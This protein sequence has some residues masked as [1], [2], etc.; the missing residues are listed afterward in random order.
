MSTIEF[1]PAELAYIARQDR[2]RFLFKRGQDLTDADAA[3]LARNLTL[4]P[5]RR[6]ELVAHAAELAAASGREAEQAKARRLAQGGA[7]DAHTRHTGA[8]GR[9]TGDRYPLWNGPGFENWEAVWNA[10]A[11]WAGA[12]I[13]AELDPDTDFSPLA[14][15]GYFDGTVWKELFERA[16]AQ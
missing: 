8:I 3:R 16:A 7:L 1:T 6:A 15:D 10:L 11:D 4:P 9:I 5:A 2:V 14:I 12:L 13:V